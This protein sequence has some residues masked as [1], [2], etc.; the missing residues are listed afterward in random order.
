LA[1]TTT[2]STDPDNGGDHRPDPHTDQHLFEPERLDPSLQVHL[3]RPDHELWDPAERFVYSVFRTS[4]F[5]KESPREWVEETQPWRDDSTLHVVT[6]DDGRV[7][8]VCRTILGE[9]DDLPVSQFRPQIQIKPGVLCEIGSL[10]VRP[11]QRGLGVANELHR[12]AFQ[13][14]IS[15]GAGGFCFLIDRWMFEF[16]ATH[17]GLPV[18]QLAPSRNFMGGDVVPTAM[19]MPEMLEQIAVIRPR[20]YKWSVEGLPAHLW[21]ELDLP[22]VLD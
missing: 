20:V 1:L 15:S 3:V 7:M 12:V 4:G 13:T 22:I 2:Y 10:A 16:F 17:Y 18:R 6:E 11:S 9:Y 21:A 5:C 8:G 14:G 19:W